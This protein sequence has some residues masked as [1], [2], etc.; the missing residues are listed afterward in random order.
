VIYTLLWI[1]WF[2]IFAIVEAFALHNDMPGDTLSEHV[3]KWLS[4]HT[5]LGRSIFLV[6]WAG[7]SVWFLVHIVTK[8]V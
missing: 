4:V 7:F 5:K 2:L 3:R 8:L 1:G 6:V